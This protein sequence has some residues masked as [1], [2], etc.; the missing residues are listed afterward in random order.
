MEIYFYFCKVSIYGN[1][2]ILPLLPKSFS[3]FKNLFRNGYNTRELV[4]QLV[5]TDGNLHKNYW[6]CILTQDTF[7]LLFSL[8]S[9]CVKKFI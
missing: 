2:C 8:L 5:N 1:N 9:I 6:G 3:V 7:S 4:I